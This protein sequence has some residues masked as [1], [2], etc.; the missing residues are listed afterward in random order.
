LTIA[1]DASYSV[2]EELS[3]LGLYSREIL[4]G[5]AAAHPEAR[6]DFCYRPHR[7]RGSREIRLPANARRRLLVDQFG[8]FSAAARAD[9][10]AISASFMRVISAR[11]A[12]CDFVFVSPEACTFFNDSCALT[13]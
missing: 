10:A 6:F 4:D 13:S 5:L 2:G 3:G 11:N 1:L 7:Y 12:T 8:P 9:S